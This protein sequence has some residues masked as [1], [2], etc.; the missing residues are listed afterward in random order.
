MRIRQCICGGG[1]KLV[2]ENDTK[3]PSPELTRA[4]VLPRCQ[5]GRDARA[6]LNYLYSLDPKPLK[7]F[8]EQGALIVHPLP[9]I[10]PLH[11]IPIGMR[12]I[13]STSA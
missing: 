1:E 13:L 5:G 10:M 11:S 7:I 4:F 9:V 3:T 6:I 12:G 8:A 2:G